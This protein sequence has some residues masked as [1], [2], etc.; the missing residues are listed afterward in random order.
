MK[1]FFDHDVKWLSCKS[2][3]PYPHLA[4]FLKAV[5]IRLFCTRAIGYTEK[6]LARVFSTTRIARPHSIQVPDVGRSLAS[7]QVPGTVDRSALY[8]GTEYR[9]EVWPHYR[10]Q[11][12][13][14]GLASIQ[15][16]D[17]GRGL[18]STRYR[19]S[20]GYRDVASLQVH[21]EVWPLH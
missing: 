3:R 4:P 6:G 12:Q 2:R 14:R 7:V 10:Y 9:G 15:V 16:P 11:V 5:K 21:G 8:T 13:G 20:T 1:F 19:D 18:A 17:T